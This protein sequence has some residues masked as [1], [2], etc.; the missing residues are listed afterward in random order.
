MEGTASWGV[1]SG[2]IS[3]DGQFGS[4]CKILLTGASG[5]IGSLV[6]EKLLRSTTVG[7]VYVL[8][9]PHRGAEP[10]ERLAAML[11]GAAVFHLIRP[12]AHMARVVAVAGDV[13]LPGLGL[14]AQEEAR[15]LAEV[16]TVIHCAA[17]GRALRHEDEC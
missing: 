5:F 8:M 7:L 10:A 1:G 14:C 16:D 3:I 9:R 13:A 2:R 6:L 11:H 12:P 4:S 17:G 15:L